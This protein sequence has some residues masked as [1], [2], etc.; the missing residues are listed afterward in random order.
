MD[1]GKGCS[2]RESRGSF[3]QTDPIPT[4]A[5]KLGPRFLDIARTQDNQEA[6]I[7]QKKNIVP[8]DTSRSK[9][10]VNARVDR[11][12]AAT[13]QAIAACGGD[14]RATVEARIVANEFLEAEIEAQVSR[15]YLSGQKYR[16]TS[17]L[18]QKQP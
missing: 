15:G 11:P 5:A 4:A 9:E 17:M 8:S 3:F 7:E 1:R 18:V 6:R 13:D 16:G 10:P 14:T 12:D 2:R